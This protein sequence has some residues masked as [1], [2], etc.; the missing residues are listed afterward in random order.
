[1]NFHSDHRI[2]NPQGPHEVQEFTPDTPYQ[3]PTRVLQNVLH[4]AWPSDE[5]L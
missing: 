1:M 3:H 5:A 2:A 4:I